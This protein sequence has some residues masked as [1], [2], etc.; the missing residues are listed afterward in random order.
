MDF[1]F[2]NP[3]APSYLNKAQQVG[4]AAKDREKIKNDKYLPAPP[5]YTFM[6]AIIETSG[7]WGETLH[8]FWEK[9]M[10]EVK[11]CRIQRPPQETWNAV[12]WEQLWLQ[13]LSNTQRSQH[14]HII[15]KGLEK[16]RI[17]HFGTP[18]TTPTGCPLHNW[19][20][21]HLSGDET[22]VEEELV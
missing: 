16:A 21:D 22:D 3:T 7:R 2:I 6:P 17:K 11:E 5:G 10:K 20:E 9:I 15:M 19:F 12:T 8:K 4:G 1:S 14:A 13:K 18:Y